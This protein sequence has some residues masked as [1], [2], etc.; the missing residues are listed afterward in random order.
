MP[1]CAN[2]MHD[3]I[4]VKERILICLNVNFGKRAVPLPAPK[5][6]RSPGGPQGAWEKRPPSLQ[7]PRGPWGALGGPSGGPRSY[8][9]APPPRG[10]LGSPGAFQG[11]SAGAGGPVRPRAS[12]GA[13]GTLGLPPGA[14]GAPGALGRALGPPG[15]PAP[16]KDFKII[17]S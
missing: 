10:L 16:T 8:S 12:R 5:G 6:L 14:L 7:T 4:T 1:R 15:P 3:V 9:L 13:P 2:R 17:I 11:R